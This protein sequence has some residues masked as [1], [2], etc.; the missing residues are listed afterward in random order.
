[1][2]P[3]SVLLNYQYVLGGTNDTRAKVDSMNDM[4][5]VL[6]ISLLC[7]IYPRMKVGLNRFR[8]VEP[9]II[10]MESLSVMHIL[11]LIL[12]ISEK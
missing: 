8:L 3:T 2:G 11:C 4:E 7:K 1:M 6:S 12:F 10:L 9:I 5:K